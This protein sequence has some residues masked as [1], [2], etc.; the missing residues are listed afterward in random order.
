[1][2]ADEPVRAGGHVDQK[3]WL[4][5]TVLLDVRLQHLGGRESPRQ[6]K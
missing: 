2:V 5:M 3:M 4:A 1:M 6:P